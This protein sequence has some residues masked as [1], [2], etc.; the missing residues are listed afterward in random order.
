[1][2]DIVWLL[3]ASAGAKQGT[4]RFAPEGPDALP[5]AEPAAAGGAG[6][7]SQDRDESI[8]DLGRQLAVHGR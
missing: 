3:A 2:P 7:R 8:A 6:V 5:E 4:M 1:M